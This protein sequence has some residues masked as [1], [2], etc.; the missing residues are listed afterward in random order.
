MFLLNLQAE[1]SGINMRKIVNTIHKEAVLLIR[2]KEGLALMF[3]MPLILVIV[4]TLLQHKIYQNVN[5]THIQLVLIDYDQDSVGLAFRK[6]VQSS[7]IFEV[8]LITR[9]DKIKLSDAKKLVAKGKYQMGIYIPEG[10]TQII[11]NRVISVVK[12]QLPLNVMPEIDIDNQNNEKVELFFDPITKASFQNIVKGTLNEFIAKIE[13]RMVFITYSKVIDAITNQ[14]TNIVYPATSA[15]VF[16][17][18]YVSEYNRGI[19]PNAVQ[20]NVPAWTLFAMFFICMPVA[21]NII[22]ERKEGL[23]ARIK[24]I[25]VSYFIIIMGKAFVF[26]M[27]CI[28]QA[29]MII[30]VGKFLLPL[31]DMP[32]LILGSNISGLLLIVI[33]S[34]LAATGYGAMIGTLSTS[35]IQASSFGAVSV[36]ILAAL[37]GV[38]IPVYLMSQAMRNISAFSPMSWGIKGFYEVFLRNSTLIDVLPHAVKLLAFFIICISIAIVYR[39][40][41][42]TV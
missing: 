30:A 10:T 22:R 7:G 23:S 3:L 20:H 42:N 13:T 34:A 2:D 41:K 31:F 33:S 25:P 24:T 19:V 27:V 9:E 17:E 5:E 8:T 32:E 16:K 37:G 6:G 26:V 38:W 39:K 4:V 11:K 28:L 12:S 35:F 21:G 15:I 1:R 40:L 18:S 36:V 29:T 14:N